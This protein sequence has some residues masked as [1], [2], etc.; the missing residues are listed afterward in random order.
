M[1]FLSGAGTLERADLADQVNAEARQQLQDLV[2][3]THPTE[4]LRYSNMLLTL[5][6]LFGINC[7]MLQSLLFRPTPSAACFDEFVWN[8]LTAAES[9]PAA[10][11][12]GC[13]VAGSG[14]VMVE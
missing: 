10:T 9:V 1:C 7:G 8:A 2:Q 4:K 11:D 6:T 13:G 5:H 3:R 12:V 14:D